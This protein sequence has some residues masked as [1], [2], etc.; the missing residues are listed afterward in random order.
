MRCRGIHCTYCPSLSFI[1]E[2][3]DN[4]VGLLESEFSFKEK[5][6]CFIYVEIVNNQKIDLPLSVI[7]IV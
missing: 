3:S 2:I 6:Q 7:Q 1:N 4:I 5:K